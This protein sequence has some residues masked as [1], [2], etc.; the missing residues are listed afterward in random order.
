MGLLSS[1]VIA[2]LLFYAVYF[3]VNTDVS[4]FWYWLGGGVVVGIIV[5]ILLMKFVKVGASIAAGWGGAAA[6]ILLNSLFLF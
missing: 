5:G 6:G 1:V 3:N 2:C 4:Q